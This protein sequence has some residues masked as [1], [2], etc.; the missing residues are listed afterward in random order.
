M[1]ARAPDRRHTASAHPEAELAEL[2]LTQ[3]EL[4]GHEELIELRRLH[5][6]AGE[7]R[8][9]LPAVM[10]LVDKEVQQH[11]SHAIDLHIIFTLDLNLAIGVP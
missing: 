9:R 8:V 3:R 10:D 4:R 6:R 2:C 1:F 11:T 7:H 5:A